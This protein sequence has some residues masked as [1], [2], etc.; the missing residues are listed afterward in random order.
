MLDAT[1]NVNAHGAL[2]ACR[3]LK[4]DGVGSMKRRRDRKTPRRTR[5]DPNQ[6]GLFEIQ[7]ASTRVASPATPMKPPRSAVARKT[8]PVDRPAALSA[9]DA[10]VYLGVSISTLKAW[11]RARMGPPHTML[12]AR[13]VGYRTALLDAW[14]ASRTIDPDGIDR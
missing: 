14:L 6:L 1:V 11:R 12:G 2:F 4:L 9:R 8:A 7:A 5:I 13:M 3:P 10:A